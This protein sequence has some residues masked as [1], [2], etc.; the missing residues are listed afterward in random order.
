[1]KIKA[2]DKIPLSEL[3]YLDSHGVQKIKSTDLFYNQKTIV[4]GS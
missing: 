1:M 3:F 2:R 4:I